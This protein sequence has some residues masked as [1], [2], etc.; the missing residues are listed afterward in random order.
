MKPTKKQAQL[1]FDTAFA[2]ADNLKEDVEWDLKIGLYGYDVS[3]H[4]KNP[5]TD[6]EYNGYFRQYYSMMAEKEENA[7]TDEENLKGISA[8]FAEALTSLQKAN[9][10][11]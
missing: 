10:L 1:F 4:A 7:L 11:K 2:F 8:I 9:L 3:Y 6:W 5:E